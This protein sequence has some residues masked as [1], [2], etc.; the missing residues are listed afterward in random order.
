MANG[1][2]TEKVRENMK[3][4]KRE[5]NESEKQQYRGVIVVPYIRGLS[6]QLKRMASKQSFQITF[7][8]GRK[9]GRKVKELKAMAQQPLGEKQKSVVYEIPCKCNE[10]VSS[11]KHRGHLKKE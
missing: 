3:E 6:E 10:A 1:F 7:K 8:P 2:E 4:D 9:E 5:S 11:G